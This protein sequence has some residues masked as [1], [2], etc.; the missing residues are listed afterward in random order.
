MKLTV[1]IPELQEAVKTAVET[2]MRDK[3]R[4]LSA[5]KFFTL[6]ETAAL[7]Q[8]KRTTLLDKRMPYLQEIEY[9]QRGKIFWFSKNS[10]E[11]FIAKRVIR[12]FRRNH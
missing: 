7:L 3:Q 9:S 2:A 6:N 5:W 11:E 10:V 12:K 1:D 8:V 4:E